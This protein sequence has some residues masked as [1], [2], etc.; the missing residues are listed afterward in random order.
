[1]AAVHSWEEQLT[2]SWI[3]FVYMSERKA[4]YLINVSCLEQKC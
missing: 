2:N 4:N 1:M 3:V